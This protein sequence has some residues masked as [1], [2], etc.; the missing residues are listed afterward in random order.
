MFHQRVTQYLACW[1]ET[2]AETR[3]SASSTA[4]PAEPGVVTSQLALALLCDTPFDP[5][6]WRPLP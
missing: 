2:D 4:S 1:N 5:P 6:V 3:R